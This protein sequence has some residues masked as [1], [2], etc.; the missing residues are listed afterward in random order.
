[1]FGVLGFEGAKIKKEDEI[2]REEELSLYLALLE[3]R[4]LAPKPMMG[5]KIQ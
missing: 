3:A 4:Y 5:I 1:V 2:N